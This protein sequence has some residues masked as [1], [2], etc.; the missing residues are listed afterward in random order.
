MNYIINAVQDKACHAAAKVRG[1]AASPRVISAEMPY[2]RL[3]ACGREALSNSELL[4][5]ILRSGSR[6][7]PVTELA[8]HLLRLGNGDGNSLSVLYSLSREELQ[9]IPGI[10]PVKSAQIQCLLELS[11]RLAREAA[12]VRGLNLVCSNPQVVADY[13]MESLR[14]EQRERVIALFLDNRLSL[15]CEETMTIGTA[16]ASLC[17]PR[18]IY[19]RALQ[20]GAAALLLLHNHPSGNPDPSREDIALTGRIARV[21]DMMEIR[22]VDHIIIGDR[23]YCSLK[24]NGLLSRHT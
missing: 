14:H 17:S 4:A 1:A 16:D 8:K 23:C 24:E 21:G 19:R 11:R 6:Q 5:V 2:E 13:Y 7:E 9:S 18:D 20:A 15:I 10:G 12:C 3:E 22:L